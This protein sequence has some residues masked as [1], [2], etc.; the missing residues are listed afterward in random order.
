[1]IPRVRPALA[2]FL[3]CLA[4]PASAQWSPDPNAGNPVAVG[5][6]NQTA[7]VAVPDGAGGTIVV[8]KGDRFDAGSGS[9]PY[10][11][12]AQRFSATGQA[13]WSPATGVVLNADTMHPLHN[14]LFI[15]MAAVPDGTG[16]VIAVWRDNRADQGD[17]YAQRVDGTGAVQWAPNGVPVAVAAAGQLR[18]SLVPDGA[19]GAIASWQDQRNGLTNNDIF[20][21]RLNASGVAQW[22]ANGVSVCG[23]AADQLQPAL[24]S[25]GA[26]GAV[27]TWVDLRGGVVQVFAQRVSA[28]GAPQWTADGVALTNV[29]GNKSRP[30][31]VPDSTGGT[32]AAWVDGRTGD[33]DIYAQRIDGTGA[34]AWAPAGV[35]VATTPLASFPAI[36]TDGAGG[37]IVAWSDERNGPTNI[38]VFAQRLSAA[39]A[40]LWPANGVGVGGAALAQT[41]PAVIADGAGGAVVSWQD[42]RT[43]Q[44]DLYA[45]RVDPTGAPLWTVDGRPVSTA[46]DEQ[47]FVVMAPDGTGGAFLSWADARLLAN[48]T[49]VYAARVNGDGVLPVRLEG[50]AVE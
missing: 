8:W 31:V 22:T 37:A 15:S 21:Q 48:R 49:D 38:D 43:G 41:L 19:G 32:I 27:V 6:D 14:A 33:D 34:L 23:A 42:Q 9:F 16:G 12:F 45:Q 10:S 11:V 36:V 5:G 26:S 40:A 18:P 24:A 28:A 30:V 20:V 4:L 44:N 29:A 7:P 17:L 35:A 2:G 50:F 39:G 47:T 46:A 13:L 1:M 25:D 3:A